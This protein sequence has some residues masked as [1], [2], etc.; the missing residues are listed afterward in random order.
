MSSSDDDDNAYLMDTNDP[1][2]QITVES[3]I[4]RLVRCLVSEDYGDTD[5]WDQRYCESPDEYEWFMSWKYIFDYVS[6]FIKDNSVALNLGCGNSP[7]SVEMLE[8]KISKVINIDISKVVIEQMKSKY[9]DNSNLIWLP[10]SCTKLE[11]DDNSFDCVV[12]KGTI[13][14]LYCSSNSQQ[15]ILE[16]LNET[17]RVLKPNSHFIVI[18][19]GEPKNRSLL[20]TKSQGQMKFIKYIEVTNPKNETIKN[21]IYIFHKQ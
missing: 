7:M 17:E 8:T 10:M 4:E 14:A 9:K 21:Y 13:D 2:H 19:F 20:V 3:I 11:F 12:E 18:S 1:K 15:M 16:T 6:D 5:Y